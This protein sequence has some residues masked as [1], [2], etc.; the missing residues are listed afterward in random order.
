M[1]KLFMEEA[2]KYHVLPIDDRVLER[3]NASLVGRPTLMEGRTKMELHEGMKAMG[4]DVFIDLRNKSYRITADVVLDASAQ[5]ALVCQGGRFGGL[6]LYMK[7]GKPAFTY[8]FLGLE[9]T[10][11]QSTQPLPSGKHTIVCDFEYEGSGPGKGG[12]ITI[13]ANNEVL[14]KG[15]LNKTQPG[16]FSVDDLADVGVDLGTPVADYGSSNHF[17]GTIERISIEA[18]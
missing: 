14:A 17:N 1:Q 16:I 12:T 7:E 5:G 8:N 9:S 2:E 13:S 11:V 18:R 15:R 6:S 3:T 10:T 4:I